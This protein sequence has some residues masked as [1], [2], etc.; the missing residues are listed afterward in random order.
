MDK[1]LCHVMWCLVSGVSPLNRRFST[2]HN[3]IRAS[4]FAC[5]LSH[6]HTMRNIQLVNVVD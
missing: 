4:N 2:Y 1:W 3:V 5:A 6:L